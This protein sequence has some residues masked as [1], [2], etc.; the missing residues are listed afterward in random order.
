MKDTEIKE[1]E[2]CECVSS[3]MTIA[4]VLNIEGEKMGP[5]GILMRIDDG[6]YVCN[7]TV[8]SYVLKQH[9]QNAFVYDIYFPTKEKSSCCGAI[10]DNITYAPICVLEEIY[11][12]RKDT[13][14][15]MLSDFFEG[16]YIVNYAFKVTSH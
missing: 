13:L 12:K 2:T 9:T 6:V 4:P 7:C 15:N 3:V 5:L 14:K 8:Y 10:I 16:T 11:R 1:L